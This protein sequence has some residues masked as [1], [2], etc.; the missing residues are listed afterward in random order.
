[1]GALNTGLEEI[2]TEYVARLDS[3]DL[4]RP[5]RFEEQIKVLEK[6]GYKEYGRIPDSHYLEG[7]Y[8]NVIRFYK[9]NV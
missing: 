8:H 6:N 7:K 9:I 3:D 5:T 1:M 2:N 4:C